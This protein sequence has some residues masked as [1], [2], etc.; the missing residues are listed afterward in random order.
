MDRKREVGILTP[1]DDVL[2]QR[3]IQNDQEA[4]RE[5]FVR[6]ALFLYRLAYR[7]TLNQAIAE[8]V[9]QEAWLKI[10][11]KL[12][13][14]EEGTSFRS[15]AASICYHLCVDHIR[16]AHKQQTVDVTSLKQMLYPSRLI[17]IDYAEQNEFIESVLACIQQMP[18]TFRTA[19]A[20]RYLEDMNYQEI[21]SIMGCA[22]KTART[23]VFRATEVLREQF[24]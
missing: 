23:R 8:E 13:L 10:F 15:W 19:F 6:Y 17:P 1:S 21:A 3:C 14:Y 20:L 16:K 2:V 22:V 9:S 12:Q 5:L 4:G 18:E 24:A 11:Q 7:T